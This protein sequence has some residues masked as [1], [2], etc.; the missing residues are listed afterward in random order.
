VRIVVTGGGSGGHIY[1]A[2]AVV[3]ALHG[4]DPNLEPVFVGGTQ[5][6]EAQLVPSTGLRFVGVTT[7]KLRKLASPSTIGVLLALAKGY[8][9]ASRFLREFRPSAVVS[10][11]GY[12]A[13]ATA[14]AAARR[15]IPVVILAPDAI[16]GR[17]NLLVSRR[18]TRICLMFDE[19]RAAFPAEKTVLTGLP[20]RAGIVSNVSQSC[21][22]ESLGLD[23]GLFTVLATG[24]SQGAQYLNG[25]VQATIGML[26]PGIQVLHQV[27][28]KNAESMAAKPGYLPVA[29]LD[30]HQIPLAYRAADLTLCRCGVGSL[31]E[32]AA[33]GLPM[34][35]VPLPT[36]YA[37]HQTGNARAM[38][39]GG[40]GILMPQ[41]EL[42]P[43]S[44]A[45]AIK[46]L[47]DYA[48]KR[49]AMSAASRALGRPDA[50]EN[51]ARIALEVA[52]T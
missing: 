22:R 41:A 37:D 38:E 2:L 13:A 28:P 18:A 30:A 48:A 44:L 29:Y 34:L 11:G 5:G 43:Q 1:P 36:A 35:M 45:V 7:R 20:I 21:A 32:A 39:R 51:V 8:V 10:T 40:A 4:I 23:S 12:V 3:E 27:G 25:I 42:S 49:N 19:A 31:A 50:A 52:R 47:R 15:R 24:G 46:S 6:M 16:P 14:I 17:T 33:N 26:P 9:E